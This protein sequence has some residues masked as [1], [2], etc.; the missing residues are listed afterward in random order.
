MR[1]QSFTAEDFEKYRKKTRKEVF[2]E[3]M[4]QIIPWQ[5][6]SEAVKLHCLASKGAGRRPIGIERMLRIQF[7]QHWFELSDPG[8]E[9]ALYDSGQCASSW[10]LL[11]DRTHTLYLASRNC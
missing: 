8:V 6:M 2:L 4:D 9:E 3:E 1:Q 5:E 7:L 11:R 10:V